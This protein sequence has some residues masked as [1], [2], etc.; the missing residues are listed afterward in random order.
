MR[1][2]EPLDD[3]LKRPYTKK[4]VRFLLSFPDGEWSGLEI[5][6]SAGV[7]HMAGH[8]ALRV[9]EEQGVVVRRR[10]GSAF[11]YHLV[12]EHVLIPPLKRLLESEQGFSATL[13][14]VIRTFVESR[15]LK[16]K[17]LNVTL[18]GSVARKE[19]AARS[20]I[21][22]FVVVGD[23]TAR[24]QVEDLCM[25]PLS[26][27]I[28]SK[29]GNPLAPMVYTLKRVRQLRREKKALVSNV[30]KEGKTVLGTPLKELR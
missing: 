6:R 27:E 7:N 19:E 25:G 12:K 16:E 5:A 15:G 18:F 26:S 4:V 13:E 14:E 1:I 11:A 10:I 22:L 3:I 9:L 29:F 2:H 21:D 24:S 8:R 20:D 23:E 17:V 28:G 30:E